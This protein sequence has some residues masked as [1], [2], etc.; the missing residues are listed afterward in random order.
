MGLLSEFLHVWYSIGA[1][2]VN[3]TDEKSIGIKVI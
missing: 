3:V 2:F 1:R